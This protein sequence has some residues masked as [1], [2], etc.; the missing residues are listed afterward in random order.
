MDEKIISM[1]FKPV[2]EDV[3]AARRAVDAACRQY[4]PKP[5][6]GQLIGDLLLAVTEAMNN[7]VEHSGAKEIEIEVTAGPQK[8]MFRIITA[9]ALFD[10]TVGVAFPDLD[11]SEE[12]PEGGFGRALIMEMADVVK[13]D[14]SEGRNIL[15]FE[16]NMTK[17]EDKTDGD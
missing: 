10:P 11:D 5:E 17:K 13:Y 12:L 6:S 4:Y 16:K 2:F 8:L 3:D 9:G 1:K 14:Y 15:T 7:A